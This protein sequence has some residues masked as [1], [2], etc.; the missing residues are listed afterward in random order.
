MVTWCHQTFGPGR[1]GMDM[2]V[3]DSD[4]WLA[5]I[6]SL[7]RPGGRLCTVFRFRREADR[8]VFVLAWSGEQTP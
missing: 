8:V 4:G 2:E 6:W 5:D 1:Y 7:T 3:K